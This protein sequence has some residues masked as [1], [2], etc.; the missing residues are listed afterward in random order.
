MTRARRVSEHL[1][2]VD[3]TVGSIGERINPHYR[4]SL[5]DNPLA[6]TPLFDDQR[7]E[8]S[9][10]PPRLVKDS[11]ARL[12]ALEHLPVRDRQLTV[13]RVIAKYECIC[14]MEIA[15]E[16]QWPL[17]WISGRLKE[18]RDHCGLI[19]ADGTHLHGS[20]KYTNYKLNPEK[21]S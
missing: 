1:S 13:L 5:Q 7:D 3:L 6:G 21:F 4:R 15:E 11:A 2:D 20:R 10:T 9:L 17:H 8:I 12:H 14:S 18:L 16:L 19:V